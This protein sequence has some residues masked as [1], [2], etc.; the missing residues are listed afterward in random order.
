MKPQGFR[1]FCER[2]GRDPS[3]LR[4][5]AFLGLRLFRVVALFDLALG[6]FVLGY[7]ALAEPSF[8]LLRGGLIL[9]G[10]GLFGFLFFR[11]L[12]GKWESPT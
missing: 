10:V 2:I 5:R 1:E 9:V 6:L 11:N 4:R 8:R 3:Q 12:Q 7:A